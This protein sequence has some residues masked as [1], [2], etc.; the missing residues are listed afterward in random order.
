MSDPLSV[1][2]ATWFEALTWE[3]L[4][5]RQRE[6]ATLRLLDTVGLIA[7]GARSEAVAIARGYALRSA[8]GGASTLV[9][10]EAGLP[11]AFAALVH[12]VAAHCYDFDDTFPEAVV[13]PGS[14]IVPTALAIGEDLRANGAEILTAIAGGYEVAARLATAGVRKFHE[15]GFHPSGIFGPVVAAFVAGRLMRL[16]PET[17]ASAVGLS[18]SMSGGLLAFLDDGSWSKWLHLGWGN[19]GGILAAEFA[20]DG[21]RGPV[22]ALDGRYNL[23]AAFA[24]SAPPALGDDL[25][26]RWLNEAAVFKLYP[27][28]HVIQP[29]IDLALSVRNEVGGR[30]VERITCAVAPWAVPIVCEPAQEKRQPGTTLA[31]IASLPF[32]VAAAFVD[33]AVTLDT[34]EQANIERRDLR[35]FAARV[36]YR[37]APEL[38][39]FNA[40]VEVELSDGEVVCRAGRVAEPNAARLG[41]KFRSLATGVLAPEAVEGCAGAVASFADAA[42]ATEIARFL[43]R[44]N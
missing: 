16:P 22:G 32:N 25:G 9:G 13:H 6:L 30:S 14:A 1:R 5:H 38:G 35:A 27:C 31:A 19:F 34:L 7:R 15:R 21:F 43:R 24:E 18:A 11:A 20:R 28:A 39:G 17:V 29:Y 8:A 37:T 3:A 41:R 10:A 12:G 33:G 23:F 2:L 40:A 36:G 42:G 26:S 4:P 44:V